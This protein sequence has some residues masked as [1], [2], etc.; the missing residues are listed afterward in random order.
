MAAAK[1]VHTDMA[2]AKKVHT[3]MASAH[4]YGSS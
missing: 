3:Y 4:I 1:K 2:A